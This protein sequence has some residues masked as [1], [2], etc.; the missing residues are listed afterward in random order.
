[1]ATVQFN[2]ASGGFWQLQ[3]DDGRVFVPMG[4]LPSGF[5]TA[6]RRVTITG[7][8]RIDLAS[9]PGPIIELLAIQ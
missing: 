6:G 5:Q 4:G 3:L 8:V 1:M 2:S 9:V 7:K